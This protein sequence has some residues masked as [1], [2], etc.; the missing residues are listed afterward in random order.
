M[1]RAD[2]ILPLVRLSCASVVIAILFVC[3]LTPSPRAG[4]QDH[5]DLKQA[6]WFHQA[7]PKSWDSLYRLFRQF[8]QCDDGAIAEGF[9]QD[10]AQLFLNQWAHLDALSHIVASDK[11]FEKFVL[12][13]ID[14]TLSENELK[15]IANNSKAHCPIAEH[16]LCQSLNV[17]ANRSLNEL[18]K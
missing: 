17:E 6:D 13:H 15:S 5:C 10:V 1:K 9:S 12:R 3:S 4:A 14:A 16:R 18:R 2:C 7:N 8:G 11:S